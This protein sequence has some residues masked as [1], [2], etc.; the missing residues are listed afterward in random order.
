[1]NL[2][3]LMKTW[4][5][6]YDPIV[7]INEELKDVKDCIETYRKKNRANQLKEQEEKLALLLQIIEA[8]KG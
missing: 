4:T 1:M 2:E 5:A 8:Q 3:T 7:D 6:K